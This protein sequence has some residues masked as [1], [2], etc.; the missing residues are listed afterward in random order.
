MRFAFLRYGGEVREGIC[1]P[2]YKLAV[3]D[4]RLRKIIAVSVQLVLN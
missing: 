1:D 2:R 3:K 4:L